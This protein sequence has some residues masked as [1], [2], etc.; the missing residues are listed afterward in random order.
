MSQEGNDDKKGC[1]SGHS[2]DHSHSHKEHTEEKKDSCCSSKKCSSG[3]TTHSHSYEDAKMIFASSEHCSSMSHDVM[4]HE[5]PNCIA[6]LR[7]DGKVDVYEIDGVLKIKYITFWI[8]FFLS[9]EKWII[10]IK[11]MDKLSM[12]MVDIS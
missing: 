8:I 4:N 10:S 5:S 6:I 11:K 9:F 1:S 3:K 7:D 12:F 2:H